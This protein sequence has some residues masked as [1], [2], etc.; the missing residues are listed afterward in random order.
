MMV[1]MNHTTLQGHSA[2]PQL[3]S[4]NQGRDKDCYKVI[5]QGKIKVIKHQWMNKK[6]AHLI[7]K[8]VQNNKAAG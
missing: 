6:L 8:L 2:I 5:K 7:S 1:T 3:H 4:C